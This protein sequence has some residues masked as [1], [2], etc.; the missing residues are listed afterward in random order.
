M[1]DMIDTRNGLPVLCLLWNIV[2]Y[3]G[4]GGGVGPRRTAPH[5]MA[6]P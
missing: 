1:A 3:W 6:A 2:Q 5:A 4:G